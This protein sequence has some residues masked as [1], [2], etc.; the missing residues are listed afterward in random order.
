MGYKRPKQNMKKL[1]LVLIM[2]IAL[3]ATSCKS[4]SST[5]SY[6]DPTNILRTATVA[7]LDVAD[8]KITFTYEPSL[9]VRRGGDK[10]VIKTAV[11]E[12]LRINGEGDV[13]VGLEYITVEKFTILP[14]VSKIKQITISGRP[15]TYKNFHSLSDDVWAPTKLYP[16]NVEHKNN[17]ILIRR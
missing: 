13:L 5:A 11:Q 16:D 2:I 9:A 3:G 7:D 8:E 1:H 14:F 17:N 6:Q 4:I 15:A 10:N 12:A